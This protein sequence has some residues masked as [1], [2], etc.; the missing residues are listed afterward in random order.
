MKI[1]SVKENPQ[2]FKGSGIQYIRKGENYFRVGK[3]GVLKQVDPNTPVLSSG[4]Y[5]GRTSHTTV[6]AYCATPA[7]YFPKLTALIKNIANKLHIT[8]EANRAHGVHPSLA[9]A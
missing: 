7:D 2:N 3:N 8:K 4:F 1:N 5:S 6:K 9:K